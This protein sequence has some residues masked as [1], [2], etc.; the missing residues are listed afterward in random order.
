MPQTLAVSARRISFAVAALPLPPREPQMKTRVNDAKD[1]DQGQG[2]LFG[3][4]LA[5]LPVLPAAVPVKA[6][7]STAHPVRPQQPSRSTA[8]RAAGALASARRGKGKPFDAKGLAEP[9]LITKDNVDDPN[10]WGNSVR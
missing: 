6:R 9:I 2:F 1:L 10:V 8:R 3:L 4:A 7:R 5:S